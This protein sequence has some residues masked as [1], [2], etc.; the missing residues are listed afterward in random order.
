MSKSARLGRGS[1]GLIVVSG[2]LTFLIFSAPQ[3]ISN[4]EAALL[5]GGADKCTCKTDDAAKGCFDKNPSD[6]YTR[7]AT[8]STPAGRCRLKNGGGPTMNQCTDTAKP[9]KCQDNT[10]DL[11]CTNIAEGTTGHPCDGFQKWKCVDD[12]EGRPHNGSFPLD[13][14]SRPMDGKWIADGNPNPATCGK[15]RLHD[16]NNALPNP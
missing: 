5:V 12:Q 4:A 13:E 9:K 11:K 8:P 6:D 1:T 16:C 14:N 7:D 15:K 3:S 2:I 10:V